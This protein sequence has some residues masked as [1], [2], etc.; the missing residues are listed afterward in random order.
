ME[1]KDI[2]KKVKQIEIKTR[3]KTEA[4][5]MGQYHSAFKGQGMT[6]SEV[7][8]YQFGDEIRM[9]DWNKTARFRE[10]YVKM[11]EEER[12]LTVMLLVDIS[13]SMNYGSKYALKNEYIAEICASIGFSAVGNNDKVGLIL[14]AD[15]VYKVIPPKKGRQHIFSIISQILSTEYVPTETDVAAALHY[16]M[17]VF[18]KKSF[19]FIFSDFNNHIDNKVVQVTAKKHAL[20]GIRV[21][22]EKDNEIPNVGYSLFRDVETGKEIWVN[23]SSSRW[24]YTFAENQK[25]LL[26][27]MKENFENASAG[28]INL[29]TNED[30][31]KPLYRYFQSK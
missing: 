25:K 4:S 30:Y 2:I 6:F 21:T 8:Q 17:N 22:D 24:R 3:R 20:L 11:M 18:K 1:V 19:L 26:K 27:T 28:F 29:L 14:F 12:E 5:L 9:I 15:K 16:M 13:A 23:T 7:R 10:P 31:T